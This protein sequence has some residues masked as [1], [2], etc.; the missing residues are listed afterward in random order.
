MAS[1]SLPGTWFAALPDG[2]VIRGIDNPDVLMARTLTL[3]GAVDELRQV[4]DKDGI[5]EAVLDR[6]GV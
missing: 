3:Q 2:S 4:I 6:W 1:R 5:E